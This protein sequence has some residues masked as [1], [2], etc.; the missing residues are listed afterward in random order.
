MAITISGSGITSANIADGTI[1]NAD[2]NDVAASKLTGALPA[3]S[4]ASLTGVG[5]TKASSNP[6]ITTNGSLGDQWVNT[7]TG[8]LFILKDAT[9]N[10][11]VWKGQDGSDVT[12]STAS[13]V[14]IF[15]DGS[16]KALYQFDNNTNDTSGNYNCTNVSSVSYTTGRLGQCLVLNNTSATFRFGY[17]LNYSSA[18]SVSAWFKVTSTAN[19]NYYINGTDSGNI[20]KV[21]NATLGSQ[22]NISNSWDTFEYTVTADVWNHYVITNAGSG[23]L[24]IYV[25]GTLRATKT[26]AN[27]ITGSPAYDYHRHYAGTTNLDQVRIFNKAL[28]TSEVTTL[29]GET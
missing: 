5:P 13:V 1:V 24:K 21:Y 27:I 3:I 28:S 11:N 16:C 20:L 2:V 15:S 7:T 4:G 23:D 26:T 29:Y 25:G 10:N 17:Q 18:W 22:M 8:E 6:L 19:G 12:P 14:D 9:S